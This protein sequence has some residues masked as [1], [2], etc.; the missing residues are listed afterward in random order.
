ME[1]TALRSVPH[2]DRSA[3]TDNMN[4]FRNPIRRVGA[5]PPEP[6]PDV[7]QIDR[8]GLPPVMSTHTSGDGR[9]VI[10]LTLD[11]QRIYRVHQF[12][13]FTHSY[14][15]IWMSFW[16]HESVGLITKDRNVVMDEVER[17]ILGHE[18]ESTIPT[19]HQ[20]AEQDGGGNS[21]ALRASP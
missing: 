7:T 2:L 11:H 13:W 16:D 1:A 10:L 17:R 19:R 12:K 15:D 14:D 8:I 9:C 6:T 18:R 3:K 21:A 20:Q 4:P 5:F